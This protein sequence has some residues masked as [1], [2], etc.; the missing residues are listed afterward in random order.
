MS[1]GND[2][3]DGGNDTCYSQRYVHH[4]ATEEGRVK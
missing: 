3:D 1:D 4:G 2:D